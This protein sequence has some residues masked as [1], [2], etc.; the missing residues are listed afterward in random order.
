MI[1]SILAVL[2]IILA[3]IFLL[4]KGDFLI[5]GYN[6]ASEEERK[7]VDIRR[8][9]ILM[10]VIS[11]ITACFCVTLNLIREDKNLIVTAS[12]IFILITFIFLI[13]ANTWAKK[14]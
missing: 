2:F 8:L 9:R 6:T 7:E 10:A 13:L 4:G 1:G 3:V 5:A 12:I 11:V 14:K